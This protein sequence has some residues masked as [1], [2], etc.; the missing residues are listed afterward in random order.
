MGRPNDG[1]CKILT[2]EDPVEYEIDGIMQV[3]VNLAT[4]LTFASALRAFLR[5]DPD[6]IMV[7]EIRD[8]ETAQIAIQASL[9]GHLVLTTLHTPDAMG[10]VTRLVDMGVEPF[11]LGATLEGV[12]AQ[13]LV[14]R[15]CPDC[16]RVPV[17]LDAALAGEWGPVAGGASTAGWR[18]PGCAACKGI[19]YR[20]RVGIFEWAPVFSELRDAISAGAPAQVLRRIVREAG[21]P[22]LRDEAWRLVCAGETSLEEA[23]RFV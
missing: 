2:V 3:P 8:A 14:R 6:T 12:L 4:G 5:Q 22:G 16:G 7:G 21:W 18:T 1:E 23:M 9:T 10:A 11:L 13:R 20:G 17:F 19:G 15:L